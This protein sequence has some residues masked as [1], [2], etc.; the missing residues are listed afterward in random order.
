MAGSDSPQQEAMPRREVIAAA[1]VMMQTLLGT[2]YAWSVF[3]KPLMAAH[4]WTRG[5]VGLTF[6]LVIFCIGAAAALGGRFVDRTGARRVAALAA[7]M[8]GVG[9]LLAGVAAHWG[10]LWLLWLGYGIIGGLGNGLGYVTPVAVL[11]RW[12]PDKRG[13]ITGLTV[14]GFGLGAAITGQIAPVLIESI[15]LSATFFLMGAVVTVLLSLAATRMTNPPAGWQPTGWQPG[16]TEAAEAAQPCD[17]RGAL[18]MYQFYLLWG[19]LFINVTA[20]IALIS[21][22]SPMAQSQIGFTPV[23]AG[24]VVFAASLC[25]GLGRIFWSWISDRIGRKRVFLLI[26]GTQVPLLLLLP[27]VTSPVAFV[28]ICCYIL[29]CYGGGFSTM[30]AFVADTFGA[31]C[32]GDIYGKVLLAWGAAGVVGPLLMEYVQRQ[33][34]SFASA[35]YIA[36]GL[37]LVGFGL[38]CTYR[39]P[40]LAVVPVTT[41]AG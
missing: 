30:P 8:F 15:G 12:F 22:L 24:T 37:L 21:N 36:A 20:G 3:K 25:N 39:R 4:G 1:G 29:L 27:G 28:A 7:A 10:L 6:T 9:T 18:G 11:V 35:L 38:V 32:L 14:M 31:Q 19:T 13:F 17:L 23:A 2:V 40:Q 16:K 33:S 34:G 41:D 5:Q 26:L